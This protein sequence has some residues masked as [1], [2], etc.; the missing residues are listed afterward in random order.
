MKKIVRASLLSVV[1]LGGWTVV[2]QA[3]TLDEALAKAYSTS[4]RLQAR[5]AQVRAVDEQV[6]QANAGWKP[7][8]NGSGNYGYSQQVYQGTESSNHPRGMGLQLSQPLLKLQTY[9]A[10]Q[11]ARRAVDAAR[12][13]LTS[14]EQQ[15]LFDAVTSYMN[16]VRD[17]SVLK[18]QQSNEQVLKRQLEAA[19]DRFRVGEITRTDVSQAES[20]LAGAAAER[21]QAVGN[22]AASKAN[23]RRVIGAEAESVK[24]PTAMPVL[25]AGLDDAV[26]LAESVNPDVIAAKFAYEQSDN[27]VDANL[28]KLL[29][30][31][32]IVGS[33]GRAYGQSSVLKERADSLTIGLSAT[34]PLYQGGAEYARTR[35]SKQTRS[36]RQLE[37]EETKLRAHEAVIK[38]WQQHDA[39]VAAIESR[40]SAVK[41]N[42]IAL[43][44]T[45]QEAKVGT[46]TTL[47]VLNAE[48]EYLNAQ[49]NLVSA[50]HDAVVAAYQIM[51]AVG[52]LT[53]NNLKLPVKPYDP[54]AHYDDVA[55]KWIGVGGDD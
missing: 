17:Q 2:A 26:G 7:V 25:P 42:A 46:R 40:R 41:A 36:Q 10:I 38:A 32:S 16:V 49:V 30:E 5:Q 19:R 37:F 18:L 21:I 31:I 28:A 6:A 23:Y 14:Q 13:D 15:L 44:G 39:A 22:L 9:P 35:Q 1:M 55:G 29:P 47:D 51:V 12:A 27:E 11:A 43:D 8:L 53:V 48:Q 4:P 52:Q 34:V 24:Q 33:A 45:Q 20:R 3:E 54:Q 50:E